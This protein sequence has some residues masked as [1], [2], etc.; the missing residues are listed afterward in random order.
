MPV[1]P[2]VSLETTPIPSDLP[3]RVNI[4]LTSVFLWVSRRG[5]PSKDLRR[6]HPED[7]KKE[8]ES[9]TV[10]VRDWF[11]SKWVKWDTNI[12]SLFSTGKVGGVS[13]REEEPTTWSGLRP[14][15]KEVSSHKISLFLIRPP[16][17]VFYVSSNLFF[18]VSLPP[19]ITIRDILG[20]RFPSLSDMEVEPEVEERVEERERILERDKPLV[21]VERAKS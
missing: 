14:Y 4:N 8:T 21:V 16:F 9:R 17:T 3:S 5:D 19:S 12:W 7:D 11:S 20:P 13:R 6:T 1:H 18:L 2:G 10:T 15:A